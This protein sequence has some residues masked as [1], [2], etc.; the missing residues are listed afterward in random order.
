MNQLSQ[1]LM[2][3]NMVENH[4]CNMQSPKQ[5]LDKAKNYLC[6]INRKL[7]SVFL[8]HNID[9][10]QSV[11][12]FLDDFQNFKI[13][14]KCTCGESIH[15]VLSKGFELHYEFLYVIQLYQIAMVLHQYPQECKNSSF[16]NLLS[17][18]SRHY[19]PVLYFVNGEA[20]IKMKTR[21][22]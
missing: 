7:P 14:S 9:K 5:L 2:Y 17:T 6:S 3:V 12:M 20:V 18:A 15:F 13:I 4:V 19:I 16:S 11:R 1:S 22:M 21:Q 8:T 10:H